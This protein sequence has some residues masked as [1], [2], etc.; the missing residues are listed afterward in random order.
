[1]PEPE[2]AK[3]SLVYLT[4]PLRDSL[5]QARTSLSH[6]HNYAFP[7]GD[8]TNPTPGVG[9]EKKKYISKCLP[10]LQKKKLFLVGVMMDDRNPLNHRWKRRERP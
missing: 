9:E 1:M 3:F 8:V 7:G 4:P 2:L 10:D 5:V 6:T